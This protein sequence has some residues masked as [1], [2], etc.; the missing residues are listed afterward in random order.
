[1]HHIHP[2]YSLKVG[3]VD[4]VDALVRIA[5]PYDVCV[6]QRVL[7]AETTSFGSM[8]DGVIGWT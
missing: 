7:P 3:R 4:N 1:M 2:G 8:H 5:A 6:G